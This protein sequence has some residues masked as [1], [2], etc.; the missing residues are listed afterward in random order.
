MNIKLIV[1]MCF[2][3]GSVAICRA[4]QPQCTAD[5][6]Y[7]GVAC[8]PAIDPPPQGKGCA[9]D[10]GPCSCPQGSTTGTCAN[11]AVCMCDN[12]TTTT[13]T[14]PGGGVCPPVT[15]VCEGNQPTVTVVNP[16]PAQPDYIPCRLVKKHGVVMVKCPKPNYHGRVLVPFSGSAVGAF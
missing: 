14:L 3:I 4:D 8:C 1:G 2:V 10:N 15:C 6:H 12:G 5:R 11:G 16:C 9:A 13:T 7:D